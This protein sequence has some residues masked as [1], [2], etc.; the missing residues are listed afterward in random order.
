L[1]FWK[2]IATARAFS[3]SVFSASGKPKGGDTREVQDEQDLRGL[4]A[5]EG[6]QAFA[7][8]QQREIGLP[9]NDP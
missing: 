8:K 4:M 5:A 1:T 7:I 2:K 3:D 9:G 6:S